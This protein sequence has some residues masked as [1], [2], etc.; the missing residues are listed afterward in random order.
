MWESERSG[1]CEK[2]KERCTALCFR[3]GFGC[4]A[5]ALDTDSGSF[6]PCRGDALNGQE[7]RAEYRGGAASAGI[8]LVAS[9]LMLAWY[10]F[11]CLR[12]MTFVG[13]CVFPIHI[14]IYTHTQCVIYK[15]GGKPIILVNR[16]V[17]KVVGMGKRPLG[18]KRAYC[19]VFSHPMLSLSFLIHLTSKAQ[20]VVEKGENSQG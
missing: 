13:L 7:D 2:E 11:S 17:S 1:C 5:S 16:I 19:A 6:S 12:K 18:E 9:C 3:Y 20:D 8:V 4:A 15:R 14:Y 10:S